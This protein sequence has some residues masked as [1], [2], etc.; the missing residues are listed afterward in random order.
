MYYWSASRSHTVHIPAY[1]IIF[2]TG[3]R[4]QGAITFLHSLLS[5]VDYTPPTSLW[6][7]LTQ[8][9]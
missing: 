3:H 7:R 5:G 2:N 9:S 4:V 8:V 1:S 6:A